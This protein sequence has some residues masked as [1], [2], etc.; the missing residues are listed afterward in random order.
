MSAGM[1]AL[2]ITIDTEY[3]ANLASR[4]GFDRRRNYARTIS[5]ETAEGSVGIEYQMDIFDRFG[6][7]GVFFVDPMPALVWGVEAI[8]DVIAPIVARG[9]DVQLHVHPDWLQLAGPDSPLRVGP[10]FNIRDFHFED[11]CRI[12]DY[13]RSTL[14]AAGAPPP[15]AF[16]AGNYGANDDTL[17]ALAALGMRYDTS[18]CPGFVSDSAIS[19]GP[20]D[21]H[22]VEHC[23]VVEVP[24]GC[25]AGP[26]GGFRH[27]QLT[28]LTTAELLGAMRHAVSRRHPSI[29]MVSHSFELLSRDRT[30]INHIVRRRFERFCEGLSMLPQL[31]TST[32]ADDPPVPAPA[33]LRQDVLP[34]RPLQTAGRLVEQGLSNAIYDSAPGIRLSNSL[35]RV[36]QFKTRCAMKLASSAGIWQALGEDVLLL[37]AA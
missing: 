29:T 22:A 5:C 30:R 27:L 28:A 18:H 4:I 3:S 34:H 12:L 15:V 1:T 19:L 11:Q 24:V 36:R 31:R 6:L 33:A 17:R 8:T 25:I 23:G 14:I 2:F 10:G 35:A 9:H 37:S 13:A 7:K 20:Q 26:G 21:R 16:R 32:Y